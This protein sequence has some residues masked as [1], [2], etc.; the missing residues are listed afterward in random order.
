M[1]TATVSRPSDIQI[2]PFDTTGVGWV[3]FELAPEQLIE[4]GE[5]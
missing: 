4:T 1:G 5:T 3:V 2:G